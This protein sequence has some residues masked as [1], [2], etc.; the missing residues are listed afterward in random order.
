MSFP[1]NG[2]QSLMWTLVEV[3]RVRA[4]REAERTGWPLPAEIVAHLW[5]YT[6]GLTGP[7]G[8]DRPPHGA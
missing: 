3:A 8:S 6:H 4:Q 2:L 7:S 5:L 1:H